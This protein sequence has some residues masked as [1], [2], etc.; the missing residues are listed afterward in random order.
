[1]SPPDSLD[2]LRNKIITEGNLPFV[3]N[4]FMRVAV[5]QMQTH[6]TLSVA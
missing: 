3:Q 5:S 1:M 4:Y 2:D 6:A